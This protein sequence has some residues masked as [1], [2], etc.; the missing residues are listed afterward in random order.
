MADEEKQSVAD[1]TDADAEAKAHEADGAQEKE[2]SL[3]D[4]LSQYEQKDEQTS[5]SEPEQ[6]GD[7]ESSEPD[8][9]DLYQQMQSLVDQQAQERFNRDM[10]EAI[11]TVRGDLD[12][13]VADDALVRGW[14]DAR[15][16]EDRRLAN[17]WA[18]RHQDP[19]GFQKVLKRL[20]RELSQKFSSLPDKKATEDREAVAAAVRGASNQA[21][22]SDDIDADKV[23]KMSD[24]EF[25][26][27]AQQ[28]ARKAG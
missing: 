3:D 4:L 7:R 12:P 21:P 15:A 16:S 17:A 9:K 10:S 1:Q 5:K 25:E 23:A 2:E 24:A 28:M 8:P 14:L 22:E 11:E 20:N 18:Q 13:E 6:T 27:F 26:K 19:K